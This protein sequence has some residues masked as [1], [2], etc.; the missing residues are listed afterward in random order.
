M[1][2]HLQDVGE[3]SLAARYESLIR[4]SQVLDIFRTADRLCNFV[5]AELEGVVH[6]DVIG[7]TKF[8]KQ[9]T[10]VTWLMLDVKTHNLNAKP[11]A[12]DGTVSQ[13]VFES[14]QPLVIADVD[15]EE[16]CPASME[17]LRQMGIRSVCVFPLKTPVRRIGAIY[18]GRCYPD[19]FP[20]EEV[21]FL[22]LVAGTIGM[23]VGSAL[24][25]E[26]TQRVQAELSHEKSRLKLLLDLTNSLGSSERLDIQLLKIAVSLRQI[27]RSDIAGVILPEAGTER[28]RASAFDSSERAA[29]SEAEALPYF[30]SVSREVCHAG[31][32]W[33]G[34]TD[35]LPPQWLRDPSKQTAACIKTIC[36]FPLVSRSCTVGVLE[37]GRV[38]E[39]TFTRDDL[40]LLGEVARQVAIALENTLAYDRI[41]DLKDKLVQEKLYLEDELHREFIGAEIV[42]ESVAL[43]RVLQKVEIVAPTDSIVLISGETG[44]GKELIARALHKLSSRRTSAFVKLNCAAI[45]L[46]LLESELFGHEKGAFTGAVA[47]RI[48]R[49]ELAN[50]GTLFLD[51]IGEVPLEV[52]PKLLHVLQEQEF[53]RLGSSHTTRTDARLIVATNRDLAT[54]VENMEFRS[55]LFYRINVVPIYV[56]PL[57]E[58]AEDIPLL[59]RYFVQRFAKRL[60]K[61]LETIPTETMN[62]LCHYRW[63]GNIRELQNVLERAVIL[64]PGSVLEIPLGD[65][66]PAEERSPQDRDGTLLELERKHILA[67]LEDTN[68]VVAGK[69]GA[70]ARLGLKRSTLQSRMQKLGISRPPK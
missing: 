29:I 33:S 62:A 3:L 70:A 53:E 31:T 25:F 47:K 20:E 64:S 35:D 34:R 58:R 36:L 39:N 49:F 8:D 28:L 45:P 9:T 54:M 11:I 48:G 41:A 40:A 10:E 60:R 21:R 32:P 52:Q 24:C 56:P 18:F 59:V 57:R 14:Q 27:M 23:A 50:H 55:D 26:A 51:E 15:R 16:G 37:L 1:N 44:T 7:I 42:G 22:S 17:R 46:G 6:C 66:L 13:L 12:W 65:I 63:P 43:R 4:L 5:V 19:A 67:V 30:D 69:N 68:W 2:I 38:V 61:N